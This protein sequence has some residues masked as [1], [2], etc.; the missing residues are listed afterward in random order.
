[1]IAEFLNRGVVLGELTR[2]QADL[3][4]QLTQAAT[5]GAAPSPA[6]AE[7]ATLLQAT[8]A[9]EQ[10]TPSGQE[11]FE[12]PKSERRDPKLRAAPLEDF[13]FLSRDPIMSSMQSALEEVALQ[14]SGATVLQPPQDDTRRGPEQSVIIT[15]QKLAR[16]P[17]PT[18]SDS[19]RRVF[20]KFSVTDI[21]W[22]RSLVAE[23]VT[24][25]RGKHAFSTSPGEPVQLP[26]RARLIL[27]GDWGSGLPRAQKVAQQ[28]R[29]VIDQG[30]EDGISQHVVH[31]G[32][33][34]YSGWGKEY[35]RR[36][37]PYWPVRPEEAERIG[38]WSTNSNHDMYSGG[39]AYFDVL[40]ADPRFSAQNRCSY[41]SFVHPHW[42]IAGLDT[43]WTEGLLQ[44][45]Q[46]PWLEEQMKDRARKTLLLSHH[47]L[48]S[49]YEKDTPGLREQLEPFLNRYGVKAWFWGHE[50]RC[51]LYESNAG[52]DFGRCIGHGGVPVYM[53]HA[54]DGKYPSPATYEYRESLKRGLEK[55]A[56][57]GFAVLDLDGP[58]IDVRYIDEYGTKHH[59]EQIG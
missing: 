10:A 35:E 11:G 17:P 27:V 12:P 41:F 39:H 16:A 28:M 8:I 21:S 15:E 51:V 9:R 36:F 4:S 46:L 3:H 57:F 31:L 23:G 34:Y 59:T 22:V 19:G 1:V 43:A 29:A 42:R 5:A 48:F 32:D 2:M 50:H 30:L 14:T 49:V 20:D 54:N 25:F 37:L 6:E 47:Q 33:V 53:W 24:K 7:L 38:S 52:V 26:S 45:P 58:A 56:L 55:W 40:L 44:E 18:R 13:V